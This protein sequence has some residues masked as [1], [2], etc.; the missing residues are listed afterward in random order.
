MEVYVSAV[1]HP[2]HFWVQVIDAKS[3]RLDM[4]M[5][6]MT[7]YYSNPTI[8]Q[9]NRAIDPCPGDIVA[10]SFHSDPMWFRARVLEV[11]ENLVDVYYVDYGDSELIPRSQVMTLRRDFLSLPFQ[12]FECSLAEVQPVGGE[13]AEEAIIL[14]ESLTY[15]AKWKVLMAQ[16]LY[17]THD[18]FGSIP[19]VRLVDT[20]G[21]TDVNIAETL[22]Q[23]G[24]AIWTH[25][26]NDSSLHA[27]AETP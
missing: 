22:V 19:C 17:Y 13:W 15:V 16:M 1:E 2:G 7:R 6:D 5:E 3:V 12:A 23:K 18:Q 20:S 9:A 27:T 10:A 25:S 21:S 4:L 24:F 8:T 14:F 11:K 26:L